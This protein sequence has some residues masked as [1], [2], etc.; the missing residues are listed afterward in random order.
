LM[1]KLVFL[2][3]LL[4]LAGAI[5][6]LAPSG[7]VRRHA[8]VVASGFSLAAFVVACV[9]AA[10]VFSSD[11]PG[12]RSE[13]VLFP[14][15]SMHGY[16]VSMGFLA[17]PLSAV[18]ILFVTGVSFLIFVYS[19]GYMKGDADYRKFFLYLSLFLGSMCA[20]VLGENLLV[21]FVGWEGVGLCS[22]LLIAFWFERDSAA[23]AGKKAMIVNRLG[24]LGFL[25][26]MFL[27][28]SKLHT[29]SYLGIFNGSHRLSSGVVLAFLLLLF[30]GAVGKS[31]Q[32]PLVGWLPDAMEGPTPVSALIHAATMVTAG[33]YLMTRMA[34]VL[35]QSP[36]AAEVVAA[37]GM[38]TAFFGATA[39]CAQDDIKRILAYSTV[40]QLGYMFAGV[41]AGAYAAAIFLMVTHAFYKAGLFLAAGS[42]IHEMKDEQNVKRMGGLIRLMPVT[43]ASFLVGWL[44]IA[45]V[46][47][48]SG[49]WSKGEVLAGAYSYSVALYAFGLATAIVTAYY[50][51]REFCLVFLGTYRGPRNLHIGEP[52]LVMGL[53]VVLL[54]VLS[55][56]GGAFGYMIIPSLEH[57][58]GFL[59]VE[60]ARV[61][62]STRV[63]LGIGDAVAALAGALGALAIWSKRVDVPS[64]EPALL[65]AAWY[66]DYM[67][68]RLLARPATRLAQ[69]VAEWI[70]AQGIDRGVRSL[71]RVAVV[72]FDAA[73][74]LA[75]GYLR[76]YLL[77]FGLG[78]VAV[79]VY[80][81]LRA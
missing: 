52:G 39:G 71:P 20:L 42:V 80:V 68:D 49:F 61:A 54:A 58:L 47:P 78:V 36:T 31:A 6:L 1:Q 7:L 2:V 40:S 34:P 70:E 48:F 28:F 33:V 62:T 79:L 10:G 18:M 77:V 30:A 29:L 50:M 15:L 41:G 25:A 17:D 16:T 8:G 56:A 24:D 27:V 22:Y 60:G 23:S 67:L 43:G 37:V 14:F 19:V 63:W 12:H 69:V 46:F 59:G 57:Y 38:A 4:P 11:S 64:L 13:V 26:A 55:A 66:Y 44:S 75:T 5:V 76:R 53:P 81:G 73:R 3:P 65:R 51:G 45:G 32:I 9:A 74:S 72:L 21:T 35:S